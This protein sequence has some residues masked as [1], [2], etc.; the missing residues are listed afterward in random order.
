MLD[1]AFRIHSDLGLRFNNAT[2]NGSIVPISS[3]LHTG[4]IVVI[5]PFKN[6]FSASHNWFEYLH[7][8][9]AKSKLTK[10][11]KTKERKDLLDRSMKLLDEK[12]K[13]FQ[14]PALY[15]K[16]DRITK[17][18]KNEQFDRV[19]LQLL[20]KQFGYYTFLR[21]IYKDQLADN[22]VLHDQE[23]E[24]KKAMQVVHTPLAETIIVDGDM[25]IGYFF[26][27]ECRPAVGAK[28]IARSGKDGIKIHRMNCV[29]LQSI[30]YNKL[31]EAHWVGEQQNIY[32]F[33]LKILC[34]DQPGILLQL[35]EC[36][37]S[38]RLN[39]T[40]IHSELHGDGQQYVY[41]N[42]DVNNPAKIHFLINELKKRVSSLK[43]VKKTLD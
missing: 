30:S 2:V 33:S 34:D 10:F 25:S 22:Q 15:S 3:V 7:T 31:L 41:L 4:D 12:L 35:F 1:F 24:K 18:Y 17:Q 43:I 37:S 14:L 38:L 8:P 5:N 11:L 29:A 42:V 39:I 13:E 28:I 19:L 9:S 21:K 26:C 32:K 36:F 40:G 6:R 27:P 23:K 16:D 20:D